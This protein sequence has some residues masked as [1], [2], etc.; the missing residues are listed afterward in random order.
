MKG[1]W[2][3]GADAFGVKPEGAEGEGVAIC[4]ACNSAMIVYFDFS[5]ARKLSHPAGH[6]PLGRIR[7]FARNE[8]RLVSLVDV[9]EET[10]FAM[11]GVLP[12]PPLQEVPAHLPP[13]VER[14]MVDAERAFLRRDWNG[15][16]AHYRKAVDRAVSMILRKV[17]SGDKLAGKMLGAKLGILED[18]GLLPEPMLD[19]IR[20][21][22]DQGN[23]ALHE[24]DRDFDSAAEIEPAR[25]FARLLLEYLFTLPE[26][27]RLA[28]EGV[29]QD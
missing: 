20:I 23:F 18:A 8:N 29:V 27:V 12:N 7:D 2:K 28:R 21:V 22:K 16:A 13:K 17:G 25:R 6:D 10:G 9:R 4:G 5:A 11:L 26:E 1:A 3:A 14:A 15:A 24:D 19:W